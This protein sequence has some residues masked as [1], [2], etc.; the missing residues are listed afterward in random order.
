MNRGWVVRAAV[1]VAVC[2]VVGT[3]TTG[4]ETKNSA[5]Q[6]AA[7]T[8][9]RA[10]A[11]ASKQDL[12]TLAELTATDDPGALR[13]AGDLLAGASSRIANVTVG[14]ASSTT[15]PADIADTVPYGLIYADF[16]R[17]DVGYRLAAKTYR[18]SVVLAHPKA[19]AGHDP[20]SW[21]I[22]QPLTGSI[23][24]A[25]V[26]AGSDVGVDVYLDGIRIVRRLSTRMN[27]DT[28]T[29]QPLYPAVYKV[30]QRLDPYYASAVDP[31]TVT[32]KD[33]PAPKQATLATATTRK[34]LTKQVWAQFARCET[35][36]VR[37]PVFDLVERRDPDI[38]VSGW[39]VGLAKKPKLKFSNDGQVTLTAGR[40]RYRDPEGTHELDFDASGEWEL[41]VVTM[42]PYL[43]DIDAEQ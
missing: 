1:A 8:Y 5:A 4:C 26:E 29:V 35:D 19:E 27:T 28:D 17:V 42:K 31:I 2:A 23:S 34:L 10:V 24:W 25:N 37:C 43:F 33:V 20:A 30:Q 11:G 7:R 12:V 38:D 13:T 14:S 21:R 36:Y 6:A 9:L 22:V 39:W 18:G 16:T 15:E 3:L 41:D 40:L 32:R